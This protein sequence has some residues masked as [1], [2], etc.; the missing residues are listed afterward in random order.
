[1]DFLR[2]LGLQQDNSG[3]YNGEW[4]ACRG[5]WLE[6][7]DLV[8]AIRALRDQAERMR[9]HELERAVRMLAKGDEPQKVL[10]QLSHSLTN[11]FLHTPTHAL[12][13]AE[14]SDRE[15]LV[16]A[17]TRLYEINPPE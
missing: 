14:A 10:E 15:A 16:A 8:P 12:N 11:K 9:R 7:R 3:A 2:E 6:S 4:L 13:S 1:M 17:L 5:E